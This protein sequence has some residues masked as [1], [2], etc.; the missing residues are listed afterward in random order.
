VAGDLR[1]EAGAAV[2]KSLPREFVFGF[3]P[4]DLYLVTP[5]IPKDWP[6]FEAVADVVEEMG[7]D[8]IV[9]FSLNA[10]PVSISNTGEVVVS[11]TEDERLLVEEQGAQLAARIGGRQ[12]LAVGERLKLAID[13]RHLYFF[14]IV[15]GEALAR[16]R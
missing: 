15:T 6:R 16:V 11:G 1:I 14:D 9:T 8:S 10:V 12:D 7:S 2:T 5:E 3:R 13:R 4:T